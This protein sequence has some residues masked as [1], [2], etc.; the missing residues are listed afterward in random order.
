MLGETVLSLLIVHVPSGVNEY[1]FTFFCAII[2]AVLMQ[3]LHFQ[4]EPCHPEL[5]AVRRNKNA[6]MMYS[7]FNQFYS[8]ALVAIGFSYKMMLTLFNVEVIPNEDTTAENDNHSRRRLAGGGGDEVI[9]IAERDDRRSSVAIFFC[10]S[11]VLALVFLDLMSLAHKSAGDNTLSDRAKSPVKQ[12]MFV[13]SMIKLLTTI[14]IG[15]TVFITNEPSI[16]ALMGLIVL[17]VS[18][19][20][21]IVMEELGKVAS[22]KIKITSSHA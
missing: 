17:L 19:G 1:Y 15:L 8:A 12:K 11:M 20:C 13:A 16:L 21:R 4:S 7:I 6:G 9:S 18:V 5:H 22:Q 2:S 10:I 3:F 14:L